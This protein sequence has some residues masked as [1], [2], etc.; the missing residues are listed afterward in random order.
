MTKFLINLAVFVLLLAVFVATLYFAE[1]IP[2]GFHNGRLI[3][4]RYFCSDVC[5]QGG[6]WHKEYFGINTREEC[7]KVGGRPFIDPAW[8]G[9]V[10]CIPQ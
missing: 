8:R 9:F 7:E 3:I 10:G 4:Y 2:T 6:D 5:P 1:G